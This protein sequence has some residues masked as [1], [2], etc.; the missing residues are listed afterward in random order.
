MS[1]A[2][3]DK[4]A[5]SWIDIKTHFKG[6]S[7]GSFVAMPNH[8]HGIITIKEG[9]AR[10]ARG[11]DQ[12]SAVAQAKMKGQKLAR[13]GLPQILGVFKAESARAI[14]IMRSTP[15]ELVWDEIMHDH[16]IA[17]NRELK[18]LEQH[19]ATNPENW[20]TDELFA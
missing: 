14:N 1:R 7:L 5:R 11:T 17:D 20:Q 4:L 19:I 9:G 3:V 15:D 18:A 6:V 12:A 16:V 8:V 10:H 2:I 13:I